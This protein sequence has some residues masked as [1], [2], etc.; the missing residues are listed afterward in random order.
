MNRVILKKKIIPYTYKMMISYLLLVLVS[1]VFIG[2]VSFMM[3]TKSRTEIA[4]TNIRTSMAQTSNNLKYQLDEIQRISDTLFSNAAFQR[5]LQKKG[6]PHDIYLTMIDDVIPQMQAPLQLFGNPIRIILYTNNSD[7][8]IIEGN[9]LS[10]PLEESDYY[11]LDT[12]E[13]KESKWL[14]N[15]M[16]GNDNR[17]MQ[18][19][20]DSELRNISLIRRMISF[21]DYRV[22]GILRI[23]VGF[24]DLLGNYVTFPEE[25]GITM[26]LIDGVTGAILFQ[27]G[28]ADQEVVSSHDYLTLKQEV[29]DSDFI[30][31]TWVPHDYLKKDA[32]RL[33]GIILA[34]CTI[35]FLVM[36]LVGFLVAR[37]SG[38]KIRKIISLVHAFENGSFEKRL[39]FSGN[40]EFSRIADA[41]NVMA[42]NI[43]ELINNVYIL[44]IKRNQAELDALQAQINPHFLYNSL[45]TISSLANLGETRQVTEMVK[46]LSKFYRLTLNQ[47]KLL[48]PL[49]KELEQVEMYMNI[50][51]VKYADA[52]A[53]NKDID[54]EILDV[55][56]IKLILQPFVE[57]VFK[58]AWFG[59]T[60]AIHITGRKLGNRIELK[61]IDNGVGMRPETVQYMFS[62]TGQEGGYGLQNVNERIQLRYGQE[63]GIEIGSVFGAGTTVRILLPIEQPSDVEI[64]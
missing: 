47:G 60:I 8:N 58:H 43:Q 10:E 30:I 44:G 29:P 42:A 16:E 32:Q 15:I 36:V 18:V 57:N 9:E 39:R 63:Y 37:I 19:E 2:Y 22:S 64:G 40:D 25:D 33:Q 28:G 31:E 59:D 49:R 34:V 5:A 61:V 24:A 41:F 14:G 52:F 1:D 11:V 4:E 56:V 12:E 46:R 48:I 13:I 7:L 35:S 51:K 3:L 27:R 26:R 38:R 62:G 50:Q 21:N 45:S 55:P 54:P 20:S 17:W 23:T 6:G 53:F